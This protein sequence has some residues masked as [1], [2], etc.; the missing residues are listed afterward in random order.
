MLLLTFSHCKAPTKP[1]WV[2]QVLPLRTWY[3]SCSQS[4]TGQAWGKK[5]LIWHGE[6]RGSA[7]KWISQGHTA[8]RG[9]TSQH[10]SQC[11]FHYNTEFHSI[12]FLTFLPALIQYLLSSSW[13]PVPILSA[14]KQWWSM[15][16]HPLPWGRM[17]LS[18]SNNK[19]WASTYYVL[20]TTRALQLQR[21]MKQM[22]SLPSSTS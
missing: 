11:S 10:Q 2:D 9:A 12:C 7:E 19:D 22:K 21:W 14:G 20:G 17:Q 8:R 18:C 16:P 1:F 4:L 6:I 15:Q 5:G 13:V 3:T